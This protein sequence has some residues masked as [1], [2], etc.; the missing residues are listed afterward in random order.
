MS[1]PCPPTPPSTLTYG[2]L[3]AVDGLLLRVDP[4]SDVSPGHDGWRRKW[5]IFS[6]KLSL[7][8]SRRR[9]GEKQRRVKSIRKRKVRG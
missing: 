1:L 7:D 6:R 4:L 8:D 9:C 5:K 2:S 3:D